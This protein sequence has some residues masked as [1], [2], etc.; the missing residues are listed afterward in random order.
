[1]IVWGVIFQD[2]FA[3]I[4]ISDNAQMAYLSCA[5]AEKEIDCVFVSEKAGISLCKEALETIVDKASIF[6]FRG[7]LYSNANASKIKSAASVLG[8]HFSFG[9]KITRTENGYAVVIDSNQKYDIELAEKIYSVV[10]RCGEI[11]KGV[12]QNRLRKFDINGTLGHMVRT[13]VLVES[14][15]THPRNLSKCYTYSICR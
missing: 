13:G 10:S 2:G 15:K 12:L 14:V 8:L 6:Q 1:M 11:K 9:E 5:V 3:E 4:G 7:K